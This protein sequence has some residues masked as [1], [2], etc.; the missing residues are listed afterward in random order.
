MSRGVRGGTREIVRP[1][2]PRRVRA[3]R[4]AVSLPGAPDQTVLEGGD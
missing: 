4:A 1:F 2:R 3:T